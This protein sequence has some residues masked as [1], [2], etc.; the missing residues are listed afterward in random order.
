MVPISYGR[1]LVRAI[2]GQGCE[3]LAQV[4]LEFRAVGD[5]CGTIRRR[6][7]LS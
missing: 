6:D 5:E 7:L 2:E 1:V 4:M 3:K